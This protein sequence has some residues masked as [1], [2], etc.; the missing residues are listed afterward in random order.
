MS[1]TKG[2]DSSNIKADTVEIGIARSKIA[3]EP[4]KVF[5]RGNGGN[6][7]FMFSPDEAVDIARKILSTAL[8]ARKA[9][10]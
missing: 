3:E 1:E 7:I 8:S 4:P 10:R 9:K 5:L 6:T 2:T